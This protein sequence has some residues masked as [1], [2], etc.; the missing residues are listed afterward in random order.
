[1][2][3]LKEQGAKAFFWDLAGKITMQGMGFIVSIFLARLLEPSDF[4]LIAIVMVII[5]IA[6]IFSDVGL[7]GALVQR[8]RVLPVHYSSVFFFNLFVGAIL[9]IGTYF[10]APWIAGFYHNESLISLTHTLSILYLLGAFSAVQ[11][12]KLRKELNYALLTKLNLTASMIGGIVGVTMAFGGAG[13]WALVAQSLMQSIV[14]NILIWYKSQWRPKFQFSFKALFQL[15]AFGFRMFLSRVLDTVFTRLDTLIIGRL[16]EPATLGFFNRAKA[17]DQMVINYSSGSLMSVLFPVLAKVQ[18]DL[19]RF[20]HIIQKSLGIIVF[21]VFLL[22]GGLYLVSHELILLLFGAKWLQSVVYFKIL[23]LSGF[24]YPVSALLV[25]VLSSRGNSKAFL[26]LEIYKKIVF[27]LNLAIGFIWGIEGYLYGLVLA[28]FI[29]VYMNIVFA[30]NE[31]SIPKWRFIEPI[32]LQMILTVFL[33]VMVVLVTKYM[34][35]GL[36]PMLVIKGGLFVLLY[37]IVNRLLNTN[38]YNYFM[39]EF[40]PVVKSLKVKVMA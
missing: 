28:T 6:G 20:R 27:G 10:S 34:Q 36:F 9:A 38:V 35:Y 23:V 31:I 16:F 32:L 26:R 21:I 11:S 17:L 5:G 13:V 8:R 29:A 33:V 40:Q 14:Y 24:G 3:N 37:F 7:G 22:L 2:E 39:E 4:G 19:K 12:T 25:N 1:M 18:H 15:W 30:S